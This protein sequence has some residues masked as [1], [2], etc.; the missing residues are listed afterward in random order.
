MIACKIFMFVDDQSVMGA[1]A[2]DLSWQARD[3]LESC[4]QADQAS[5]TS[6]TLDIYRIGRGL[7]TTG[8]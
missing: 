7:S 1:A 2:E 6:W 5:S 4:N 3:A 8:V